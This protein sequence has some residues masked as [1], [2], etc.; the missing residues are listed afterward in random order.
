MEL[1]RKAIY[2]VGGH[3]TDTP[4]SM[5]YVSVLSRD[6]VRLAL[7]IV[8]LNYLDILAGETQNAYLNAPKKQKAPFYA[9]D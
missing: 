2:M 9:G 5:N 1:T 3:L 6:S 4:S 8:A 7:L